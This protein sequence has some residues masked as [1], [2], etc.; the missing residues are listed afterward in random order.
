MLYVQ[1][2]ATDAELRGL[3][4]EHMKQKFWDLEEKTRV[5][6]YY[7]SGPDLDRAEPEVHRPESSPKRTPGWRGGRPVEEKA[8]RGGG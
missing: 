1:M 5:R 3:E 4:Q 8:A 6:V 2:G 7:S